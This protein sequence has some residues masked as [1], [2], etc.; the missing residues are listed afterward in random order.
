LTRPSTRQ[1]RERRSDTDRPA[2]GNETSHY[3]NFA[4]RHFHLAGLVDGRVKPGHDGFHC[5]FTGSASVQGRRL[6]SLNPPRI[7]TSRSRNRVLGGAGE[8]KNITET[9]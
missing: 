6:S 9:R 7:L 4:R 3:C 1:M 2:G 5:R 8:I